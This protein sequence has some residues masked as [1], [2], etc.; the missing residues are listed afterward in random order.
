MIKGY[1]AL[2]H[3]KYSKSASGIFIFS[4]IMFILYLQKNYPNKN[5]FIK[6]K[7][8]MAMKKK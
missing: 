6:N 7:N 2:S 4:A 8:D 3:V 5:C 1:E